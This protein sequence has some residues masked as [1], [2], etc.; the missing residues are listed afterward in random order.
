[1]V[2][3]EYDQ[4]YKPAPS[5]PLPAAAQKPKTLFDSLPMLR[6]RTPVT[7]QDELDTYLGSDPETTDDPIT[8]WVNN[9]GRFPTLSRMALD[10]LNIPGKF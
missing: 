10:Y 4:R 7:A 5:D 1:M 2:R 6:P 9:A 3:T 8:W